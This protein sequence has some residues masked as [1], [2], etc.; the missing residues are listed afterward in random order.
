MEKQQPRYFISWRLIYSWSLR[1]REKKIHSLGARDQGLSTINLGIGG[2]GPLLQLA[3]YREYVTYNNVKP[4]IL[5][6]VF[7]LKTLEI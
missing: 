6:W 4:K 7:L 1:G 5:A 2:T 3:A